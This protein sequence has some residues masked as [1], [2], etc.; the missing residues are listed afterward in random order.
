MSQSPHSS[1][2]QGHMWPTWFSLSPLTNK[3]V[4]HVWLVI[5]PVHEYTDLIHLT[6]VPF[7]LAVP[8]QRKFLVDTKREVNI[9]KPWGSCVIIR[10]IPPMFSAARVNGNIA[11]SG[12]QTSGWTDHGILAGT[13]LTRRETNAETILY[14]DLSWSGANVYCWK[15]KL[16]YDI[17]CTWNI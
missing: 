3:T 5:F 14:S 9:Y 7:L 11:R 10:F 1:I 12:K 17:L 16:P 4:L 6:L 13:S 2:T 8:S 15:G